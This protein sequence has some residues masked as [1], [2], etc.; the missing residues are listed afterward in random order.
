MEEPTVHHEPEQGKFY[1]LKDDH[2]AYMEYG[3]LRVD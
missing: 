2:E 3:D 1:I